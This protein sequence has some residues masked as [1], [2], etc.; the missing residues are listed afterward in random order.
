[1]FTIR[2]AIRTAF[3][4]L[5]P[6]HTGVKANIPAPELPVT[7]GIPGRSPTSFARRTWSL[8]MLPEAG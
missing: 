5:L 6:G 1:M 2:G 3:A 4:D 7:G 8:P